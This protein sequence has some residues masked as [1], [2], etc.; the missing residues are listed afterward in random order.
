MAPRRRW[1]GSMSVAGSK[2]ISNTISEVAQPLSGEANDYD[3][4]LALVGDRP[5]CLLGTKPWNL[6][7]VM[8]FGKLEN[9]R[10]LIQLECEVI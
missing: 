2:I 4:L 9:R 3:P 5:L 8:R 7:S 1:K 10:K 6:W